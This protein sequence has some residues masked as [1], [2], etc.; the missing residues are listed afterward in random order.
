MFIYLIDFLKVPTFGSVVRALESQIQRYAADSDFVQ[1]IQFSTSPT[2]FLAAALGSIRTGIM[3]YDINDG[4]RWDFYRK[5]CGMFA[6]FSDVTIA[7][8]AKRIENDYR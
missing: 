8:I 1:F 7:D 5:L 3:D 6:A 4:I 2:F